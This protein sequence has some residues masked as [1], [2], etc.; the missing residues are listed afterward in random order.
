MLALAL[1]FGDGYEE[2]VRRLVGSLRH[3]GTS[4]RG[5]LA[6]STAALTKA[7]AR[8]GPGPIR[9]LFQRVAVPMAPVGSRVHIWPGGGS[10]LSVVPDTF[11]KNAR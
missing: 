11:S 7:R 6:P 1:F 2:M 9:V 8:L 5:W 3:I 10:W 4:Q